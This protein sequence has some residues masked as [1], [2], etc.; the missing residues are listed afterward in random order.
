MDGESSLERYL[1]QCDAEDV[2]ASSHMFTP[3]TP[4][5]DLAI[6]PLP[7]TSY[8][9]TLEHSKEL[10]TDFSSVDLSF[11]PDDLNQENEDQQEQTPSQSLEHDSGICLDA[12]NLSQPFTPSECRDATQ[13]SSNLCTMPITPMTPMTPMTPVA[14]SSGIVPQLQNIVS[15]VNLACK[16]DLKKIALHA[17]NAEYNPKR[18]AA[19][20]MRI[21]EPRTTALIFSSGKMVCTGAK[22][23]EQSRLAARKYAR[24]VQKLGFPAKFLD[25]KIQ[26][27]VGSCDVRFPIRLEGLVLT[28]QQFSSYEPELFPGLI[29]RMVKPRIVLLIFVSGKVVLTGAKER[30]EIYEAFENI[31]PILK[32][33]KKTT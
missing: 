22:S 2:L 18:F 8:S 7:G 1:D 9:S 29:Y 31:Y 19:V 5:D 23:E 4:Y 27:M 25:F 16:L 28:H 24:V 21:R 15:T 6:Q 10:S 32:G 30:S 17:R 3:M 20:I 14:E 11:L 13:D 26:N 33:F 12:S